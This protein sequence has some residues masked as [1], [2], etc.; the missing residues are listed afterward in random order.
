MDQFADDDDEA[1]GEKKSRFKN[2]KN[3][4]DV[5]KFKRDKNT[6]TVKTDDKTQKPDKVFKPMGKVTL[7]AKWGDEEDEDKKLAAE[8][9]K[10]LDEQ[11][12]N[13]DAK[14]KP[15]IKKEP[16]FVGKANIGDKAKHYEEEEKERQ[17]L[18]Q[19]KL[20]QMNKNLEQPQVKIELVKDT[21]TSRF[22]NSKKDVDNKFKKPK[23]DNNNSTNNKVVTTSTQHNRKEEGA[24]TNT[25]A[26][27]LS[28]V[29]TTASKW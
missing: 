7:G 25:Q 27:V 28:T 5:N 15:E 13:E 24:K 1:D 2:S 6:P 19:E 22:T 12:K 10:M 11:A 9:L 17:R 4:G 18:A 20:E 21:K 8:K 23:D 14:P 29:A 3:T 26:Q 16:K